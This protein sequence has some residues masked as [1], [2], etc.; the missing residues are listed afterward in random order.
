MTTP[1]YNSGPVIC[2]WCQKELRP[3]DPTK[4]V[5]HGICLPCLG[6]AIQIP[7]Q[8]LTHIPA[9]VFD[10]L[11][12]GAIQLK[13]DGTVIGYNRTEASLSGL[14]PARVIG[15]NFFREIAPCTLVREFSGELEKMRAAGV[16][17]RTEF[18]FLFKFVRGSMMVHLAMVYDAASDTAV[19]LVRPLAKELDRAS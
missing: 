9:D 5:S 13:G 12:Y 19:V 8:D 1:I 16:N 3:G 11:P 7:I 14:D 15:K 4:P 18:K 17:A 10:N 2:A 6:F